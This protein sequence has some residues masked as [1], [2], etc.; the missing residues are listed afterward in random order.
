[1]LI[2]LL[3]IFISG[4]AGFI[5]GLLGGG[6]GLIMIPSILAILAADGI[7]PGLTMHMA[8]GTAMGSCLIL[9]LTSTFLQYQRGAIVW[10]A[11]NRLL[12]GILA[13]TVCGSV[14]AILIPGQQLKWFFGVLVVALGLWMILHKEHSKKWQANLPIYLGGGFVSAALNSLVGVAT[15]TVPFLHKCGFDIRHSVGTATPLTFIVSLLGVIVFACLGWHNPSLPAH[16]LGYVYLPIVIPFSI[17]SA[18]F[19][20]VGAQMSH[21]ISRILLKNCYIILLFIVGIKML[22]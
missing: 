5:S 22:T 8:I 2:Y 17:G 1:M 13:G 16:S 6:A 10:P 20:Y 12:G 19:A 9:G 18:I 3:Y 21:R 7:A 11:F 14:I 4:L 15:F